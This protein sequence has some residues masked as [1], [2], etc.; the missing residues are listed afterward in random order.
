MG[1]QVGTPLTI[2]TQGF[3]D[4][5][6]IASLELNHKPV[7]SAKRGDT[8]AMKIEAT[9]ASESTKLYGRSV[10]LLT[11]PY[12]CAIST[13]LRAIL[14]MNLFGRYQRRLHAKRC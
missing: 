7:D 12:P 10:R 9:N 4:L 13:V 6:R 8:V 2:P 11:L 5:G 14:M 3:L 1:R